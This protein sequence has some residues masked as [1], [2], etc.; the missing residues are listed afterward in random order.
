MQSNPYTPGELPRVL[1][2]RE[3]QTS[4]IR[5]YLSRIATYGEMGGPLL[6]FHG[7]RGVGKTSLLR[8]AERDAAEHGFV[9]VW[10]SCRRNAG[11]LADLVSRIDQVVE[12]AGILS[13][14]ERSRWRMR[15]DRVAV[16]IGVPS[17]VKL[18]AQAAAERD[19]SAP[20]GARLSAFEDLLHESSRRLRDQGAAGL[21]VF[22]DELHAPTRDDLAVLLNAVQNLAGKREDNPLA[23]IAAGLP[24]TP[25]VL[26]KAATFG[27][28]STFVTLP[29]LDT[30]G[31]RHA[32]VDPA[33]QLG[34]DWNDEALRDIVSE[35][36]GFPYLLQVLAHATW[37]AARPDSG[38]VLDAADVRAGLPM[39]S[40]QLNTMYAARW[41]AA[42]DLEKQIM[43]VMAEAG[44]PTV[45]RADIA[46]ALGKPTQALGVP[47]ER[48]I[49]KGIIEP[50]GH[51]ELRFTM[52]G[53]DRYIRETTASGNRLDAP[54]LAPQLSAAH[55]RDHPDR[56]PDQHPQQ[57]PEAGP[58]R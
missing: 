23:V 37:E 36:Q 2:G 14:T 20:H 39:A 52:P 46:A 27:E 51:G 8:D 17:G 47:R 26:T 54:A 50:A 33:A 1:A 32:V 13:R 40:D 34:V 15:L 22:I 30:D 28:R 25:A 57:P 6:V 48:L 18:T 10:V 11:F 9:A 49:D 29:R 44:T 53:F 3:Q 55:E 5:S 58:R 4:R 21:L 43:R 42:T 12:S 31:A 38:A 45:T 56:A 16:E 19:A 41:G 24:S 7:P 35:A